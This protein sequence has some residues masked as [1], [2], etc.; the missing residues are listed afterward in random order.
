MQYTSLLVAIP[1][2][3]FR[4]YNDKVRFVSWS[5]RYQAHVTHKS[6]DV[7]ER[8]WMISMV[9]LRMKQEGVS[10]RTQARV[11]SLCGVDRKVSGGDLN[12]G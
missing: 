8:L 4:E 10:L 2:H 3:N 11:Y 5:A 12:S 1:A 7:I 6:D 9:I